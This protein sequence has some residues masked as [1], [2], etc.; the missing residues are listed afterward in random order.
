MS[1]IR[2]YIFRAVGS[3]L[4]GVCLKLRLKNCPKFSL[5]YAIAVECVIEFLLKGD[6]W[7]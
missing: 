2:R 7:V 5:F 4:E 6:H 3:D 1:I